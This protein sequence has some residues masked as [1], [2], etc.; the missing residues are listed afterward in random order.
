L[1]SQNIFLSGKEGAET[2]SLGDFGISKGLDNTLAKAKVRTDL[3]C[4]KSNFRFVN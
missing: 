3:A 1:K 2:I 4:H